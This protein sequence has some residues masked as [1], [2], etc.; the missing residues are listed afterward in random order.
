MGDLPSGLLPTDKALRVF[1]SVVS[2]NV[3][4]C[5][6]DVALQQVDRPPSQPPPKTHLLAP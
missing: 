1:V 3:A 5:L 4:G 2:T 6:I